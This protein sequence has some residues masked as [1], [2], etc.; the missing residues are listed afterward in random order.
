MGS[1][2]SV[3]VEH[4]KPDV[5]TLLDQPSMALNYEVPDLS[6]C[7][8]DWKIA[9]HITLSKIVSSVVE[10]AEQTSCGFLHNL[11]I[12][13]HG[14]EADVSLGRDGISLSNVHELAALKGLVKRIYIIFCHTI[15]PIGDHELL[16]QVARVVDCDATC[17]TAAHFTMCATRS[18]PNGA[19]H[20]TLGQYHNG[21]RPPFLGQ[22]YTATPDGSVSSVAARP[23]VATIFGSYPVT[24]CMSWCLG[25]LDNGVTPDDK[26]LAWPARWS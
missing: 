7:W 18:Q 5:N 19:A 11:V 12:N 17:G 22:V 24:D 15:D 4:P 9:R 23:G 20:G 8:S 6:N 25:S 16:K 3:Q 14:D 1:Q 10:K 2:Q 21:H 13:C 26:M